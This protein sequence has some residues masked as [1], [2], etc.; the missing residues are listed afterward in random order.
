LLHVI[1]IA[2]S[3][4]QRRSDSDSSQDNIRR[5]RDEAELVKVAKAV[6]NKPQR[7]VERRGHAIENLHAVPGPGKNHHPRPA[8]QSRT[9]NGYLFHALTILGATAMVMS[10]EGR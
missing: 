2:D 3:I 4:S 8:N 6:A 5:F 10:W 1:R 9:D 7:R